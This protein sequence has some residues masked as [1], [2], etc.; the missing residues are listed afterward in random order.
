MMPN[1]KAEPLSESSAAPGPHGWILAVGASLAAAGVALG[2]F[3]AHALGDTLGE[4]EMGWWETAVH[5]QMWHALALVAIAALPMQRTGLPA[6][7]LATGAGLFSGT[8]YVMALTGL[9][10]LGMITPIGGALMIAGWLLLA[11]RGFF[12]RPSSDRS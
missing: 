4:R 5:Y 2:A 1:G 10:W 11:W 9:R 6:A 12:T 7:F 3:G 8:L